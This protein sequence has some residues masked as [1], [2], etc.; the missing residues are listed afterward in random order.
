VIVY[1]TRNG[2]V[3]G[4]FHTVRDCRCIRA[5]NRILERTLEQA[6]RGQDRCCMHC[7]DGRIANLSLR[8]QQAQNVTASDRASS[9]RENV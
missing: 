6:L 4:M 7:R 9:S 8:W 5:S 1:Y 2:N 3:E